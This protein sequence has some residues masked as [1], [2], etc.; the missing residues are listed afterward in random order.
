LETLPNAWGSAI[1]IWRALAE[2]YIRDPVRDRECFH[3][4][5]EDVMEKI[6]PL[7]QN[8]LV[9][10]HR[11][12]AL[13]L[14]FDNW[15]VEKQHYQR[16]AADLLKF[17]ADYPVNVDYVNHWPHI[18]DLL[19]SDPDYPAIGFHWTSVTCPN[20]WYGEWDD[21]LED[22]GPFDWSQATSLYEAIDQ[23]NEQWREEGI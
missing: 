6:W 8:P 13:A 23:L 1:P 9:P 4:L 20:M 17:F 3:F 16:A 14:T 7:A 5:S 21:D 2:A 12:A 15:Y 22:Y 18:I 10:E 19:Q 11:R